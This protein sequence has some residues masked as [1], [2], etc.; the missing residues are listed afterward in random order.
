[1]TNEIPLMDD[2]QAAAAVAK[3]LEENPEL[4]QGIVPAH[5]LWPAIE[6]RIVAR[7]IPIPA[8]PVHVIGRALGLIPML[9]AASALVA[10]GAG[11]TYVLTARAEVHRTAP[12][13]VAST[14][15]GA[16]AN[17]EAPGADQIAHPRKSAAAAAHIDVAARGNHD[18]PAP[19]PEKRT[20]AQFAS[21]TEYDGS[22]DMRRTY[23]SEITILRT[24]LNARRDQLSET[25]VAIIEQN[26]RVINDAIRQSKD[27]LAKDPNSRLLN[28]QL[29]RTLAKKTGLLRAAVLLPAA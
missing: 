2:D 17:A 23:D 5:D 14:H 7:V 13:A 1:M 8:V 20:A 21:H 24:A 6:N 15:T 19:I 16:P 18:S 10:A 25:T 22:D 11:I 26:L 3:Y 27:A 29:D 12:G 4:L 28:D 9:I